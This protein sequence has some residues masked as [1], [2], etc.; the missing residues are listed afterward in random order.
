LLFHSC[1]ASFQA[2]GGILVVVVVV[3]VVAKN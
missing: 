1:C 3:V 2:I